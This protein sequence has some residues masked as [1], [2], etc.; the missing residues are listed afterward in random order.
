MSLLILLTADDFKVQKKIELNKPYEYKVSLSEIKDKKVCI[1][2]EIKVNFG[3]S[4][5]Y[6]ET[7]KDMEIV[8]ESPKEN[9]YQLESCYNA[10]P[11]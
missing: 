9:V 11:R 5:A 6:K 3:V 2:E 10:S 8:I 4:Q 1:R 7:Y